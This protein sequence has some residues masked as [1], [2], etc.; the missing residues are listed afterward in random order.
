MGQ[1]I[2]SLIGQLDQA[3]TLDDL[4]SIILTLRDQFRIDHA[5]YHWI[6]SDG[7]QFGC[8]TYPT[9]WVQTYVDND[10]LRVDPVVIGCYQRFHPVNWKRLDWSSKQARAFQKEAIAAGGSSLR[11]HVQPNGEL[12][13]FQHAFKVYDRADLPCPTPTCGRPLPRLVQTGRATFFCSKCQ[14]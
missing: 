14:R 10:Y 1:N 5:V 8:G 12:G 6:S 7:E 9:D 13:Y 4:Q 11:D 2:Q 3:D